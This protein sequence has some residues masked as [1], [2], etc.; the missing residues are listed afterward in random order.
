MLFQC[1]LGVPARRA[2]A[3]G[4]PLEPVLSCVPNVFLMCRRG[5]L[6]ACSAS[7][8]SPSASCCPACCP[9][10]CYSVA[11]LPSLPWSLHL[12]TCRAAHSGGAR[13][14]AGSGCKC[15]LLLG[16]RHPPSRPLGGAQSHGAPFRWLLC[17]LCCLRLLHVPMLL[18]VRKCACV[19]LVVY[20]LGSRV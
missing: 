20:G 18:L 15:S 5:A 9:P 10:P 2:D 17:C 11:L 3:R 8:C 14:G 7:A 16:L 12:L 6:G 1:R 19:G 4:V 13:L